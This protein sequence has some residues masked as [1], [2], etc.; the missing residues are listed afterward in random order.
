MAFVIIGRAD[1]Q[2][3]LGYVSLA[4]VITNVS[5]AA[6]ALGPAHTALREI[7]DGRAP[8]GVRAR[9]RSMVLVRA[10]ALGAALALMGVILSMT[11]G[12]RA[13]EM[14]LLTAPW[15]VGQALVLFESETLRAAGSFVGASILLSVRALV[16]WASSAACAA[17]FGGLAA[18]ILPTALV[19]L[20]SGLVA[21]RARFDRPRAED[22]SAERSIGRPIGK[23]S[24][25]SYALGYGD[26]FIVQA[27]LGPA[28]VATYTLGYQLGV[29]V[30]EMVTA[31]ITSAALP[32]MVSGWLAGGSER[33]AAERT[34]VKLGGVIMG[35]TAVAV[36]G[37]VA[38]RPTGAFDVISS[39][40]RLPIVTAIVAT[41]V[42]V[43]GITRLGYGFL[44]AQGRTGWALRAFLVAG[45]LN[46]VAAIALTAWFGLGGTAS[47]TLL[48]YGSLALIT[49]WAIKA[50]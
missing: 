28:A 17:I 37:V 5:S 31:P 15:L 2:A 23:M 8:D 47:A 38:L 46:L 18:A 20:A 24:L 36:L 45:A 30:V 3:T 11:A 16:G 25:A 21:S 32:R 34:A 26:Y 1:S 44:L 7:S 48:G 6:V 43:Q 14:L 13:G 50:P 22:R 41:A 29:G 49:V 40:P 12:A 42:G 39:D 35:V 27:M 19:G 4:W 33:A 10:A 9:F